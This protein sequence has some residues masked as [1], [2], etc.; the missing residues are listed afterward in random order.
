M[1]V[2]CYI[3][4]SGSSELYIYRLVE[5]EEYNKIFKKLAAKYSAQPGGQFAVMY[6]PLNF[7]ISTF[8]VEAFSK[9]DCFH[10]SKLGHAFH[11]KVSWRHMFARNRG[12]ISLENFD[13]KAKVFCPG[14]SD[15]FA[16]RLSDLNL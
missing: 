9:L 13:E 10:L 14:E 4:W 16:T 6:T 2:S 1:P 8:K 15:R 12:N 5:L 11:A 7:N 3:G